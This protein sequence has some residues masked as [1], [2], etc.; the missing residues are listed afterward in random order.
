MLYTDGLI[1]LF[2][3]GGIYATGVFNFSFNDIIIFGIAIN[4]TAALGAY[5]FGFIE[6]K[7]GIKKVILISLSF[8][9]IICLIIL[10]VIIKFISGC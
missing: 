7:I 5:I 9:I 8:L 10:I 4:I 2:S 6:D 3:F 1:T